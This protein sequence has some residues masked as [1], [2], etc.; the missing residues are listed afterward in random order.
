MFLQTRFL[1][2]KKS[3]FPSSPAVRERVHDGNGDLE[4]NR[5]FQ[6]QFHRR[7]QKSGR[8]KPRNS[9][10]RSARHRRQPLPDILQYVTGNI[11]PVQHSSR[12]IF[13]RARS[14]THVQTGI[15]PLAFWESERDRSIYRSARKKCAVHMILSGAPRRYL[16]FILEA[17]IWVEK[18]QF[19][20]ATEYIPSRTII[21]PGWVSSSSFYL[22]YWFDFSSWT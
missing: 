3:D 15:W 14:R 6:R 5:K 7:L 8:E 12:Q 2:G 10:R 1:L 9:V 17:E 21:Q 16:N 22:S 13:L 18:K 20:S 4:R 19:L 11:S